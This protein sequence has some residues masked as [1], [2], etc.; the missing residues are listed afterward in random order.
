MLLNIYFDAYHG[1]PKQLKI[2]AF[3]VSTSFFEKF[4]EMRHPENE[5][6]FANTLPAL[7]PKIF[8][9]LLQIALKLQAFE[10]LYQKFTE[11]VSL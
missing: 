11:I 7:S 1:F 8:W 5:E 10:N 2:F 6:I 9:K 3:H 4:C